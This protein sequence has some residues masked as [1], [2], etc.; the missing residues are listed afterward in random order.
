MF[1][2]PWSPFS[3]EFTLHAK[4]SATGPDSSTSS[5][6]WLLTARA[7]ADNPVAID[8]IIVHAFRTHIMGQSRLDF[9][10]DW[11]LVALLDLRPWSASLV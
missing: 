6:A 10:S 3:T 9:N 8:S 4:T 2:M 5:F 11:V 1:Q 7:L